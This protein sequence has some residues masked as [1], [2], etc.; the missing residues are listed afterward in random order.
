MIYSTWKPSK[1]GYDY[2]D[3]K[4]KDIP[5]ANDLPVPNI[6]SGTSIGTAS[7]ECGRP[8][9]A[10]AKYIGSGELAKGMITPVSSSGPLGVITGSFSGP[11]MWVAAGLGLSIVIRK[12]KK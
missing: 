4:D 11:L 7:I 10:G 2:F 6:P 3:G 12:L 5:M 9:P 8:K 1:G